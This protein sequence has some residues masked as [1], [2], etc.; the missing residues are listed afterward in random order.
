MTG[1]RGFPESVLVAYATKGKANAFIVAA[2]KQVYVYNARAFNNSGGAITCGICRSLSYSQLNLWTLT[3]GGTVYTNST[4]AI[5]AATAT[6]L[7]T[8]V[9]NDGYILT[10][11]RRFNLVQMTV[12]TA[13]GGGTYTYK[14]WNGSAYTT[15]TT[16]EVP[17]YSAA[18]DIWV[19]FQ[20]PSDWVVGGPASVAQD[21]YSIQVIATTHP[22]TLVAIN[23]LV[24]GEMLDLY[25]AVPDAAA[26]QLSFPDSKPFLLNGGEG[27]F[28]YFSTAAADNQFGCFYTTV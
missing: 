15:L 8:T 9:N 11:K 28:P 14:Y 1:P 6:T 12:S 2:S 18:A 4:A 13:S 22:T 7:F 20:A 21:Q 19:V 23:S 27:L 10:S 25:Q 16:L 3:T 26:V 17:V 5:A 24:V